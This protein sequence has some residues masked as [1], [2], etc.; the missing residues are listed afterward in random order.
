MTA[1]RPAAPGPAERP[2][3]VVVVNYASSE[4]LAHNLAPLGP[5][6]ARIVVV[7]NFSSSQERERVRVLADDH[8]WTLVELPDNRGFGPGVNAGAAAALALGCDGLLLLNP[9]VEVTPGVVDELRRQVQADPDV[10]VSPLLVDLTGAVNFSGSVLDLR[11]GRIR[12]VARAAAQADP[13]SRPVVWLTAAC[14]AVPQS[15]W[16]RVGG[17]AEDYFM[18][19]EDVDF[20]YRCRAAGA[21]TVLRDD[22]VAVHDQGGT[23]GER[24]GRAKSRLYYLYNCRNRMLFG[25]RHLDRGDLRRWLGATPRVSY[26]IWL[27]G[28]RRQL[29]ESPGG[30][31]AALRGCGAGLVL[32]LRALARRG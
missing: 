23:Q 28:G 21:R 24:R 32:G 9:D 20:G 27:H 14:L 18:Y 16:Q 7:D 8:G 3:G 5:A 31:L 30:A 25:A 13:R 10:L 6:T 29:L 17:L 15:L 22:L 11:D 26:E 19:W 4:L 1:G 2:L 12:S